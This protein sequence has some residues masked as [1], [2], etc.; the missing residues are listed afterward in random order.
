MSVD[1]VVPDESDLDLKRSFTDLSLPESAFTH[2]N[3]LRLGWVY[4]VSYPL[5]DAVDLFAEDLKTY[6]TH[7][8]ASKKFNMTITWFYIMMIN[9]RQ[10]RLA[11]KSWESFKTNNPEL[12]APYKTVLSRHFSDTVLN[13][14]K[15]R[16]EV[17]LPDLQSNLVVG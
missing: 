7:V 6:A 5:S 8:G 1:R 15:A 11:A 13:S 12:F 4:V 3:H 17:V 14:E 10:Q 9:E 2:E 16:L